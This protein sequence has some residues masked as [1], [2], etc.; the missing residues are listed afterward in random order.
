MKTIAK[1][2][3]LAFLICLSIS[4]AFAQSDTIDGRMRYRNYYYTEWIDQC[5]RFDNQA[6]EGIQYEKYEMSPFQ[7]HLATTGYTSQPIKVR[8]LAVMVH[9]AVDAPHISSAHAE[10]YLYLY[11][12]T[13]TFSYLNHGIFPPFQ[14][15]LLDSVRWDTA[16]P[17]IM[18]ISNAPFNLI[19]EV[20]QIKEAYFDKP[21]YVDSSF[22][23]YSSENSWERASD[24]PLIYM[25]IPYELV[26]LEPSISSI[27]TESNSAPKIATGND[28]ACR[29]GGEWTNMLALLGQTGY[30]P[31][32]NYDD[33]IVEGER[34][35]HC[36]NWPN[37]PFGPF[38][39]IV[40]HYEIRGIS[41]DESMGTVLGGGLVPEENT[42][43]LTA[44]ALP[45]Y[46]FT[47]W[48]D[49]NISNPRQVYS[50]RDTQ[51]VAYFVERDDVVEV[52]AEANNAAWGSVD[53]GG[54]YPY[55][56]T[57][58]LEAQPA[59]SCFFEMWAD[60]VLEPSR[61]VTVTSDT[62]FTA[63]FAFDS[64]LLGKTFT[65][66]PALT[67]TP[68]PA[69]TQIRVAC[70]EAM[71]LVAL[72]DMN[73]RMVLEARPNATATVL[74]VSQLPSGT[75]ILTATTPRGTASRK[76]VVQ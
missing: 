48:D 60:G 55:G 28:G 20:C 71:S 5:P 30:Y 56:S 64:S 54:V 27:S 8:G 13:D 35:W 49:G 61:S 2:I 47:H 26:Q 44:Y 4:S 52:T 45:R 67:V 22:C 51:F 50:E 59:D 38:F 16:M 70:D 76:L 53:G 23:I 68:N 32:P 29:G 25:Y 58:T 19:P 69:H 74:N 10:D 62:L 66:M 11:Q 12:R 73:G 46:R 39:A 18:C 33:T 1:T 15:T 31:G 37:D 3:S 7:Y 72:R 63:L 34:F 21:I 57:V 24:N 75:Y 6:I 36:L 41:A 14:M 17:K 65:D 9:E 43:T 42:V 40:Y